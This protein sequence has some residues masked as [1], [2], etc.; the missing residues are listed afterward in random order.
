M[1]VVVNEDPRGIFLLEVL[2]RM[3]HIVQRSHSEKHITAWSE[4]ELVR[5]WYACCLKQVLKAPVPSPRPVA[6]SDLSRREVWRTDE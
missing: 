6:P 2:N 3:M 4:D 5:R 1:Y